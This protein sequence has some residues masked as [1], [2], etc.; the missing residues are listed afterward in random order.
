MS[1][2]ATSN[3]YRFFVPASAIQHQQVV[4]EDADLV[5]QLSSVLR[6]GPGDQ[7]AL[8]DGSGSEYVVQISQLRKAE[9]RGKIRDQ[10]QPAG[11]PTLQI[12]L[13][14]GLMRAERLEWLLQK[15]TELG[16]AQFVPVLCERSVAEGGVSATK[17]A[18]W[19]RIIREAAEQSRRTRLP[20]LEQVLPYQQACARAA[21]AP[22]LLLWEGA[23]AT[24]IRS[25]LH[26]LAASPA[27]APAALRI[28]S[29]PEGGLSE[30]EYQLALADR[31][32]PVTL[33]PRIL[34]AETAPLIAASAALFAFGELGG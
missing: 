9:L 18:R 15:G 31:I 16:V 25:V 24:P 6:L 13:M 17:Q 29:G 19:Q 26:D 20:Q 30:N 27:G 33:G 32:M 7:I 1:R 4:V 14:F 5:R 23:V 21:G 3:T 28:I 12:E 8:L 10:H 34:R 11:E 2:K 22:A